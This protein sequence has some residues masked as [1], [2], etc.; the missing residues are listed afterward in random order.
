MV[1]TVHRS[2]RG[3]LLRSRGLIVV[4]SVLV[5]GLLQPV[6]AGATAATSPTAAQDS[7]STTES[8]PTDA[9]SE[10][11]GGGTRVEDLSQRTETVSTY[12]NPDGTWTTEESPLPFRVQDDAGDW[13]EIDTNL[14]QRD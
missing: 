14:V 11:V 2:H 3:R 13:H 10:A 9:M 1:P 8:D 4:A 12:A 5:V 7:P 6:S